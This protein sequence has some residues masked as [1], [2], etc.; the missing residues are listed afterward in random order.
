MGDNEIRKLGRNAVN[1][2]G[3]LAVSLLF[4]IEELF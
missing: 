4:Y 1:S 3:S 2:A